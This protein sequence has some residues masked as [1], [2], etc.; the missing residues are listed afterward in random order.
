MSVLTM[1]E[2]AKRD[3]VIHRLNPFTKGLFCLCMIAAPI[4]TINP[5]ISIPILLVLWL[6]AIPARL[7]D[8]FY[9]TMLKMYPVMLSF[10][11]IIWPFFYPKG[12]TVLIDWSFIHI[13]LEGIY[14]AI[15]QGLRIAVAITGCLFFVMTTEIIDISSALGQALQKVG[16]GYTV[17][18]MLTTSFKFL[19]EF[20]ANYTT[21]KESFM[22]RG[23]QLDKGGFVQK[24]KNFIPLFIPLIDSSLSKSQSI[25]SAMLLRAFGVV[26]KRTFFTLYSF[27][28]VDVLYIMMSLSLLVFAILGQI[29]HLGGFDLTL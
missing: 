4:I 26:K 23:F 3:S 1:M 17:P 22:T 7:Q 24:L 29:Y 6:L 12:N 11:I 5:F 18:F 28:F 15:A 16:I 20:M 14:Y 9:P 27:K 19:P 8:V 2:A 13:T 10:I 25:A 21:I